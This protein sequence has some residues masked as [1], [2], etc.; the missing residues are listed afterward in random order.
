ML[1]LVFLIAKRILDLKK[2]C[3]KNDLSKE[4]GKQKEQCQEWMSKS[5]ECGFKWDAKAHNQEI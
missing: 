1:T 3:S 2:G 4:K 5:G